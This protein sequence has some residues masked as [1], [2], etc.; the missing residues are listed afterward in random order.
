VSETLKRLSE[1][2]QSIRWENEKLLVV[3][4]LHFLVRSK[5]SMREWHVVDLEPVDQD[6]PEGGCSCRGY[7]CRRDCRHMRAVLSFLHA[8]RDGEMTSS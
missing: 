6:W 7:N 8:V 1:S 2:G 5:T 3:G 4:R